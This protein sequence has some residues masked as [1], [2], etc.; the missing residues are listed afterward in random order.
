MAVIR[1]CWQVGLLNVVYPHLHTNSQ[2]KKK[3][4]RKIVIVVGFINKIMNTNL[5][6]WQ[7]CVTN[8]MDESSFQCCIKDEG[9]PLIYALR[10]EYINHFMVL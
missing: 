4:K 8:E 10:W 9:W 3:Q 6:V 5:K 7:E 1:L 2:R